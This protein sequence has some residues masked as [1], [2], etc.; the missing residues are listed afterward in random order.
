ME[1][2]DI[3]LLVLDIAD[4]TGCHGIAEN[5]VL[6]WILALEVKRRA[7]RRELRLVTAGM[8]L[9]VLP[10]S[11]FCKWLGC[12]LERREASWTEVSAR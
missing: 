3:R 11:L 8:R 10:G 4:A 12:W 7:G 2:R 9:L 5:R 6:R 1:A